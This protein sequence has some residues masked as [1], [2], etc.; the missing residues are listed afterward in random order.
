MKDMIQEHRNKVAYYQKKQER[1]FMWAM[2]STF[3]VGSLL[4]AVVV[5]GVMSI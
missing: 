5:M 4:G 3:L 1:D 2:G